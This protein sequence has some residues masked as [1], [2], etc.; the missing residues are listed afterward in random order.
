MRKRKMKRTLLPRIREVQREEDKLRPRTW[1]KTS[2]N[3]SLALLEK[4]VDMLM[5]F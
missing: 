5:K 4:I 2:Q 1:S 3:P